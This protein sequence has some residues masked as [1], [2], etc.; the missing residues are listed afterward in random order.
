MNKSISIDE[1]VIRPAIIDDCETI[2]DF[3]CCIAEETEGM[4]LTRETVQEGVKSVLQNSQQGRYFVALSGN[5]IVGQMM[6]TWEFSDWRNGDFWWVQSV[7]VHPKARRCGLFRKLYQ[8]LKS[9]AEA[10]PHVVGL[11][12]YVEQE[13]KHA[14][15][16]YQNIG[17]TD[18]HYI[19]M[20]EMF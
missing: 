19:V 20:E 3:N 14:Q 5:E 15:K 6:Q 10:D 17:M 4:Q 7:Y 11:R 16:T 8:H 12:L 1:I 2:V 18:S 9:L 13:N